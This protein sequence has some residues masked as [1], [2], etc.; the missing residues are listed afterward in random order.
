MRHN[1]KQR[2]MQTTIIFIK[3]T[4]RDIVIQM[5]QNEHKMR[6]TFTYRFSNARQFHIQIKGQKNT[7]FILMRN[8]HKSWIQP[9]TIQILHKHIYDWWWERNR[10]TNRDFT[11]NNAYG[12]QLSTAIIIS[13]SSNKNKYMRA[14]YWNGE[15]EWKDVRWMRFE[16]NSSH[17]SLLQSHRGHNDNIDTERTTEKNKI[18]D[19]FLP[20]TH[21]LIAF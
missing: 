12:A 21:S 1:T 9:K 13:L 20:M 10:K 16:R 19:T 5:T 4:H 6:F 7:K 15:T 11:N 18:N 3:N 17:S 14:Q 8:H 2:S